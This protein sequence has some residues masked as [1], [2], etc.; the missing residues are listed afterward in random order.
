[1]PVL[2]EQ[3]DILSRA[4]WLRPRGDSSVLEHL[5]AMSVFRRKNWPLNEAAWEKGK[6]IGNEEFNHIFAE[7][8]GLDR[9]GPPRDT[10]E[11]R[12]LV[13]SSVNS[14]LRAARALL[15]SLDDINIP[16]ESLVDEKSRPTCVDR[17]ISDPLFLSGTEKRPGTLALKAYLGGPADESKSNF[18]LDFSQTYAGEKRDFGVFEDPSAEARADLEREKTNAKRQALSSA[19]KK[20]PTP[21]SR[22]KQPSTGGVDTAGGPIQSSDFYNYTIADADADITDLIQKTSG[23]ESRRGLTT[24][25]VG[26][27]R[28]VLGKYRSTLSPWFEKFEW[29]REA[30]QEAPRPDQHLAPLEAEMAAQREYIISARSWGRYNYGKLKTL[31]CTTIFLRYLRCLHTRLLMVARPN[32]DLLQARVDR[33]ADWILHEE[34]W[35]DFNQF[36][37]ARIKANSNLRPRYTAELAEREEKI[38]DWR[39]QILALEKAIA[40]KKDAKTGADTEEAETTSSTTEKAPVATT[41]EAATQ[42]NEKEE[43]KKREEEED[44]I[45]DTILD[46]ETER[47]LDP[48]RYAARMRRST[49][50]P[51]RKRYEYHM[52]DGK[53]VRVEKKPEDK[54]PEFAIFAEGGPPG[55]KE[56]PRE[57]VYDKLQYMVILTFWRVLQAKLHQL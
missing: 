15:I 20:E 42:E 36:S 5:D 28:D 18:P 26:I 24:P 19:N 49:F 21:S 40:D 17:P 44:A 16:L 12:E 57:E 14:V 35:N 51:T 47:V 27:P 33:L 48:S 23:L 3:M 43:K 7:F 13:N 54:Q 55:Y 30:I 1:M 50:R 22:T 52:E 6:L 10:F 29:A 11:G 37:L 45:L 34:V 53:Q 32:D 4:P 38:E 2:Q 31:K 39:N 41:A 9:R 46:K 56:L 8:A 25:V